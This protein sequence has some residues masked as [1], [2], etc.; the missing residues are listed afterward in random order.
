M[1]ASLATPSTSKRLTIAGW[2]LLVLLLGAA[3]ATGYGWTPTGRAS[4]ATSVITANVTANMSVS[5][6]GCGAGTISW[7]IGLGTTTESGACAITYGATNDSSVALQV[8]DND[9]TAP[10]QGTIGNTTGTTAACASLSAGDS[11][12]THITAAT[13]STINIGGA[14]CNSVDAGTTKFWAM[15]T[16]A[17]TVCTSTSAVITNSCTFQFG[18]LEAGSNLAVGSYVGTANF[19]TLD[20]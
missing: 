16:A 5:N 2:S 10:F 8:N 19:T 4:A 17:T 9:G 3:L 20:V 11:A 18:V 6:A 15:P 7:S 13:T 12:G 14:G 1:S